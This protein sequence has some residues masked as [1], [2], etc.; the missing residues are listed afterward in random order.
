MI[1]ISQNSGS[2]STANF[3][4][5]IVEQQKLKFFSSYFLGNRLPKHKYINNLRSSQHASVVNLDLSS[6]KE[7][8]GKF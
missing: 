7:G 2:L 6:E 8:K 3:K 4:N 5:T 1:L